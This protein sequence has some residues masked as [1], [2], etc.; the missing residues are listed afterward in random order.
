MLTFNLEQLTPRI[1]SMP[2]VCYIYLY[3]NLR[4][5]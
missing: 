3:M 2:N 1:R 5:T 4:G